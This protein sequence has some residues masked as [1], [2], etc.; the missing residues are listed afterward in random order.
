MGAW[1]EKS[2][3]LHDLWKAFYSKPLEEAQ[4]LQQ[5]LLERVRKIERSKEVGPAKNRVD[6]LRGLGNAIV[7]QVAEVIFKAICKFDGRR[8]VD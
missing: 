7:P 8:V 4:D 6:R 2:Q 5:E 1:I 3:G